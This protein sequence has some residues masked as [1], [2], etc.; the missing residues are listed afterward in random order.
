MKINSSFS[1]K[2]DVSITAYAWFEKK[3]SW[4]NISAK[5]IYT[6]KFW[7]LTKALKPQQLEHVDC[8]TNIKVNI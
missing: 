8:R 4:T 7:I 3:R 6:A 5:F 1:Y 2:E